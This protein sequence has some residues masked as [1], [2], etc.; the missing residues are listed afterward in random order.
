MVESLF[1]EVAGLK[2]FSCEYCKIFKSTYFKEYMRTAVS[3][4]RLLRKFTHQFTHMYPVFKQSSEA[5]LIFPD[6]FLTQC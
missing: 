5:K 6:A 1:K 4:R 2:V 3:V